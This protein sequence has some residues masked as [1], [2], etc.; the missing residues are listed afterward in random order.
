MAA[1]LLNVRENVCVR[2]PHALR[3]ARGAAAIGEHEQ[4]RFEVADVLDLG[5]APRA[6]A[7]GQE[8][9]RGRAEH[10]LRTRGKA[11]GRGGSA[12]HGRERWG[13][14]EHGRAA[15]PELVR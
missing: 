5:P 15:V 9:R 11:R 6:V 12:G 1:A 14:D 7:L 3:Q 10:E 2:E 8:A 13:G 4:R